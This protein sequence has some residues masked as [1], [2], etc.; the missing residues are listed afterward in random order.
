MMRLD[1]KGLSMAGFTI[2]LHQNSSYIDRT[3]PSKVNIYGQSAMETGPFGPCVK[4]GYCQWG[5]RMLENLADDFRRRVCVVDL[6]V[7][8]VRTPRVYELGQIGKGFDE[9]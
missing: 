4:H 6:F 9:L 3:R 7:I 5:R 2:H 8:V 1:L